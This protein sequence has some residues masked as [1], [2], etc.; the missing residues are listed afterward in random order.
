MFKLFPRNNILPNFSPHLKSCLS[1]NFK[2]FLG[3]RPA[4]FFSSD[5]P[6]IIDESIEEN[7]EREL[8]KRPQ[9]KFTERC[10]VLP[11]NMPLFP[12][13]TMLIRLGDFKFKVKF[14]GKLFYVSFLLNSFFII[15]FLLFL[16]DENTNHLKKFDFIDLFKRNADV[17]Y[18]S[19]KKRKWQ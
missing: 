10:M 14:R 12:F 2:P 4:F 3:K 15:F 7:I 18:H 1:Q 8:R 6:E 5:N 9:Y 16:I 19:R 13:S 17:F 11:V